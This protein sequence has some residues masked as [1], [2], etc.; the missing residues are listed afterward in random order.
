[1]KFIL[2]MFKNSLISIVVDYL[3]EKR[4]DV[5]KDADS[6]IAEAQNKSD[7]IVDKIFDRIIAKVK[8][9]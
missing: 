1:M 6:L 4:E 3:N 9:M 8:E 2:K 5:K 7:V